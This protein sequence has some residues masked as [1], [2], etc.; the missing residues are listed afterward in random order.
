MT[1]GIGSILSF[2]AQLYFFCISILCIYILEG[3]S[4]VYNK[5]WPVHISDILMDEVQHS[6]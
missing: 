6:L 4:L 1:F 5:I 3:N 2:A